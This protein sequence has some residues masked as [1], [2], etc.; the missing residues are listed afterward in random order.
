MFQYGYES[1][2]GK[3]KILIEVK[4]EPRIIFIH[5]SEPG[6]NYLKW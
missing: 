4:N 2:P 5:Y 6:S 1:L 3:G